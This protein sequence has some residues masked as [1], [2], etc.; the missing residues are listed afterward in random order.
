MVLRV[1]DNQGLPQ[2]STIEAEVCD[3]TG[4]DVRCKDIRAG[5]VDLPVILG[6]LAGIMLLLSEC[7]QNRLD[8]L[9]PVQS[10]LK[11]V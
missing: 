4:P 10:R 2:D 9:K 7:S 3:C 11:L 6:V 1:A 5:G 8:Q